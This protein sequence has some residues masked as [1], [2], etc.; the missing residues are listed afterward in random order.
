MRLRRRHGAEQV[1]LSVR[2]A[3]ARGSLE[4]SQQVFA[5]LEEAITG[6]DGIE[7]VESMVQEEGGSITVQLDQDA[8]DGRVATAAGVREA[9]RRAAREMSGVEI[10]RPGEAAGVGGSEGSGGAAGGG[11]QALLGG[12]P[13]RVVLSGPESG[14]L[15]ELAADVVARLESVEGVD[16]AWPSVRPGPQEI[17]VSPDRRAFDAFGLFLD[18]VL[19]VL[20]LAGREGTRVQ[21]G[22]PL[23]D[24]RELGIVVQRSEGRA[25]TAGPGGQGREVSLAGLSSLRVP[26]ASGVLPVASLAS[27]RRVPATPVITHHN[28]RRE[29][30][31]LFR[32]SQDVP[33]TGPARVALDREVSG[34]ISSLHRPS[35]TTIE[36][37]RSARTT[38]WFRKVL[39]PVVLLLYLVLA[40]TF[41]SLTLPVLVLL[42]L[43]LTLLGSVWALVLTG[44]PLDMMAALGALALFGLTVNPA[45][46]LVD[47]MQ[48]RVLGRDGAQGWSAGAA[49]LAAVKERARPVTHDHGHHGC[50]TVAARRRHR[51]R[52]RDLAAVCDARHGRPRDVDGAD[53]AHHPGGIRLSQASGR[54]VLARWAMGWS[55]RGW[56]PPSAC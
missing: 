54:A 42:S 29:R 48:Q 44:L 13:A 25:Q 23:A 8:D 22:Y 3:S 31:V 45:I 40:M 53:V 21:T 46:L 14:Q 10:L 38:E 37:E 12:A 43:P 16:A 30:A 32:A 55:S 47:R 41:E 35:G 6:L 49:A 7:R 28:G 34:A 27:V 18:D 19:P 20:T 56:S 9:V 50:R 15:T 24:G 52:E 36:L 4:R 39:V 51:T 33:R 11:A 17:R 26:T 5:R 1:Q 2:L